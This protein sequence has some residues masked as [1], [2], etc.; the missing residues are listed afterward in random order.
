V[1]KQR[2]VAAAE[3]AYEQTQR[4]RERKARVEYEADWRWRQGLTP[5]K[6]PRPGDPFAWLDQHIS[7]ER[8]ADALDERLFGDPSPLPPTL[9]ASDRTPATPPKNAPPTHEPLT[10]WPGPA[11]R[12]RP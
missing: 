5:R 3:M 2:R 9:A 10:C 4:K 11:E 7:D 8:F 1:L 6:T 12:A